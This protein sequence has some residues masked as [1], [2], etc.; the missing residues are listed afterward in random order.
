MRPIDADEL[1]NG[2]KQ[3]FCLACS[4]VYPN[5]RC[6]ACDAAECLRYID[7]SLTIEAEPVKHGRWILSEVRDSKTL[8]CSICGLDSGTI[9]EYNYCPNCGAR[10]D[11]DKE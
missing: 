7:D 11:G 10:M 5:E 3:Q 9:Y 1:K 4:S 2:I 6:G 8:C